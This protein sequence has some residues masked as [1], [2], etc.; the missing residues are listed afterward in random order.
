ML[1]QTA[2][3]LVRLALAFSQVGLLVV[4]A[5]RGYHCQSHVILAVAV[6]EKNIRAIAQFSNKIRSNYGLN[7]T[8]RQSSSL[9]PPHYRRASRPVQFEILPRRCD[10]IQK[11]V[12]LLETH[13]HFPNQN[14]RETYPRSLLSHH[15]RRAGREPRLEGSTCLGGS[16]VILA[17]LLR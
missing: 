12:E 14:Q 8:S 16:V 11:V 7:Q 2:W 6:I 5:Q 17:A 1:L 9:I 15:C 3:G 10:Q 13:N 4:L